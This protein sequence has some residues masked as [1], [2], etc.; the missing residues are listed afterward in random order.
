MIDGI[1]YIGSIVHVDKRI[2]MEIS[3][4][5]PAY[6]LTQGKMVNVQHEIAIGPK[7]KLFAASFSPTCVAIINDRLMPLP[8]ELLFNFVD[9]LLERQDFSTFSEYDPLRECLSDFKMS[10]TVLK[11]IRQLLL[12]MKEV[13]FLL[14]FRDPEY[15]RFP[16]V[17]DLLR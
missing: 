16:T 17:A 3:E 10:R 1:E 2:S 4:D 9:L 7:D 6:P 12:G 5:H 15:C 13:Q 11:P 14:F 8:D